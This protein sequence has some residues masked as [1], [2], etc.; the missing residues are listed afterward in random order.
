MFLSPRRVF[1]RR[2]RNKK[3]QSPLTLDMI[4][5]S[6]EKQT[7]HYFGKNRQGSGVFLSLTG[8]FPFPVEVRNDVAKMSW[9]REPREFILVPH[10]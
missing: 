3:P 7:R 2:E 8:V 9:R 1:G 5:P 6:L 10:W 4:F